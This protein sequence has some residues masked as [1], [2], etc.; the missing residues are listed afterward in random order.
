M[1]TSASAHVDRRYRY[2]R[3]LWAKASSSSIANYREREFIHLCRALARISLCEKPLPNVDTVAQRVDQIGETITAHLAETEKNGSRFSNL[4]PKRGTYC[5]A[6]AALLVTLLEET[7]RAEGLDGP[8]AK[9]AGVIGK[10]RLLECAEDV[11]EQKGEWVKRDA[12]EVAMRD[13]VKAPRC[14]AAQ[15]LASMES[16]GLVKEMQRKKLCATHDAY[17]LTDEGRRRAFAVRASGEAAEAGPKYSHGRVQPGERG[18]VVLLVD[19]REG[20]GTKHNLGSLADALTR[21][22]CRFE[23][24]VLPTGLGD[25]QFVLADGATGG[26]GGRERV[27]PRIIERKSAEDVALSLKDGRWAKQQAAMQLTKHEAFGGRAVL[28]CASA[29]P[30]P[31]Q[32]RLLRERA[33][34]PVHSPCPTSGA[35]PSAIHG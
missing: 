23:T 7:E 28:E 17:K 2:L 20:G 8:D 14:A 25:Y 26:S 35:A 10:L 27:V 13:G 19:E 18:A 12:Y 6:A 32:S 15:Q 29:E 11:S 5:S 3:G 21:H 24:R 9:D 16:L 33:L 22:G 30:T 4:P 31:P 34:P 1:A